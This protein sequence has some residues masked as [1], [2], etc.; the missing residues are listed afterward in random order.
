MSMLLGK[1]ND[2]APKE[3][4]DQEMNR[5]QTLVKSFKEGNEDAFNTLLEINL[6]H[7]KSIAKQYFA[8]SLTQ[9]DLIQEG[10]LGLYKALTLY[11]FERK[12]PFIVY[13]KLHVKTAIINAV[14][15]ETRKKQQILSTCNSLDEP[16]LNACF[17]TSYY[18]VTPSKDKTPE[19]IILQEIEN[20]EVRVQFQAFF[21][22]LTS[23]EKGVFLGLSCENLSYKEIA[24]QLEISL[25]AVDNARTRIKK[26]LAVL[27]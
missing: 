5:I 12:V 6:R 22:R 26:K 13:A 14:K 23:L 20:Q 16:C 7:I 18:D 1:K 24:L 2:Q 21:R 9:R 4:N 19:D 25:R 11:D 8:P 15:R 3:S 17:Y 27:F 10:S